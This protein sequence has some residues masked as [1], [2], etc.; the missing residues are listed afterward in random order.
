MD[1]MMPA[2]DSIVAATPKKPEPGFSFKGLVR[3]FT[4]P[5]K[6]FEQLK[7]NPKVLIPLLAILVLA[8]VS[9][10]LLMDQ[11]L[12]LQSQTQ[13]DSLRERGMSEAQIQ[14]I[15]DSPFMK[16]A[17]LFGAIFVLIGPLITAGLAMLIGSFMMGGQAKFK[18]VLSV[19]VFADFVYYAT[20]YI[21]IPFQIIKGTLISP[22]SLAVLVPNLTLQDPLLLLLSKVS[23]MYIW[24][25]IVAGIGLSIIFKF[26]RNKGYLLAVLS[27]GLLSALHIGSA[28]V[29]KMFQ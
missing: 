17:P 27:L 25:V 9:V 29:G 19:M 4:G 12:A 28:V 15:L 5:T 26:P 14:Q 7:D 23:L 16:I 1:Q 20:S 2:P 10:Y 11:I 22:F 6:F 8:L 13:M 3:V 21:S 24:H 18:Q